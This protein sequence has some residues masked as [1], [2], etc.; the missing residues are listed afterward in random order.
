MCLSGPKNLEPPLV[1]VFCQSA[2]DSAQSDHTMVVQSIL[3]DKEAHLEKIRTLF[4]K[5]GADVS[6]GVTFAMFEEKLP[7]LLYLYIYI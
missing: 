2:I 3:D 5:F 1:Q 4:T 7:A 6:G